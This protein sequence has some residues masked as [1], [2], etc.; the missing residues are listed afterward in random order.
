MT[1]AEYHAED[2]KRREQKKEA[3]KEQSIKSEKLLT[4]SNKIFEHDLNSKLAKCVKWIEKLH[5]VRVVISGDESDIQ[6]SEKIVTAIEKEMIP[7]GGRIL[8]KRNKD[9]TIKFS[10]LPTIKKEPKESPA[11]PA[12]PKKLLEVEKPLVEFQ[13]VRSLHSNVL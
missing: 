2:L 7:I 3:K 10:I 12:A 9:G 13:Q 1:G 5:E 6:K 11:K 8:Q 4:L